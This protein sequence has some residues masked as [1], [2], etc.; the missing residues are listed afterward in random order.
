MRLKI[1]HQTSYDYDVPVQYGLQ[2]LRLRPKSGH[3]QQILAW[4][5]SI[6]GG[7]VELEFEDQHRN[8]VDLVGIDPG[9]HQVRIVCEGEV[10]TADNA[11]VIGQ[12]RGFAPL[13]L[14]LQ[15]TSLT[16]PGAQIRRLVKQV[17]SDAD[18]GIA[19]LHALSS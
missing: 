19:R 12:H 14:F 6:E 18:D 10:E 3:G 2:Q 8:H 4:D 9:H 1:H 16:R 5:L 11:G 7:R 17:D 13:W 15:S